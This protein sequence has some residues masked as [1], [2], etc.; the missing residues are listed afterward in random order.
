MIRPVSVQNY[1]HLLFKNKLPLKGDNCV[2][3]RC[4]SLVIGKVNILEWR[5]QLQLNVAVFVVALGEDA[6]AVEDAEGVRKS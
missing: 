4:F 6:E 1:I 3:F 2:P 5:T